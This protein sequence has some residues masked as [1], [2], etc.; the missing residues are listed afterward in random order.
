MK[1]DV[2]PCPLCGAETEAEVDGDVSYYECQNDDCETAGFSWGY[3]RLEERTRIEGACALGVP[4]SLRRAASRPAE[5]ELSKSSPV[6][7]GM[8]TLRRS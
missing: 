5:R 4:E 2:Q 8:P 3:E 7:L 6:S 1:L